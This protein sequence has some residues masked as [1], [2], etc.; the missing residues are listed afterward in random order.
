MNV[1]GNGTVVHPSSPIIP[2]SC[3]VSSS[4][5]WAPPTLSSGIIPPS[6]GVSTRENQYTQSILQHQ[7]QQNPAQQYQQQHQS[8]KQ[9]HPF[10]QQSYTLVDPQHTTS[11]APGVS[12]S[13]SP[14]I[15]QYNSQIRSSNLPYPHGMDRV[16]KKHVRNESI[17][18]TF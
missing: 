7:Q 18:D 10:H 11:Q 16:G 17:C 15:P 13:Q 6:I 1:K 3:T 4:L 12:V 2:R 9:R 8:L 5:V 14:F